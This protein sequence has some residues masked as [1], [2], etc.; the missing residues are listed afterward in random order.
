MDDYSTLFDSDLAE[1]E[2]IMRQPVKSPSTCAKCAFSMAECKYVKCDLCRQYDN[3]ALRCR[4]T[5]VQ[6]GERCKFYERRHHDRP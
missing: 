6:D 1:H 4:C 2:Y 3:T 5:M